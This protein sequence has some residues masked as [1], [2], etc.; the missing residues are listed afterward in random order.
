MKKIIQEGNQVIEEKDNKQRL[1]QKKRQK[2]RMNGEP[3]K[4]TM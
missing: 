4:K 2:E 1:I 3:K